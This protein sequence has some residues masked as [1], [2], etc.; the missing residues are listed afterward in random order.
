MEE[1][2]KPTPVNDCLVALV[3]YERESGDGMLPVA[4]RL[5]RAERG[6]LNAELRGRRGFAE[7]AS[8]NMGQDGEPMGTFAR[9]PVYVVDDRSLI[10][11]VL[12]KEPEKED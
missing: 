9:L 12:E 11:I 6:L 8:P 7:I 5:G 4:I 3:A 2:P 1:Q 10:E